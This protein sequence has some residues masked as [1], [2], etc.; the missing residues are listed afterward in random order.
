MNDSL[1]LTLKFIFQELSI[2]DFERSVQLF[3]I[4]VYQVKDIL[5]LYI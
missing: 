2:I 3:L 4:Y 5:L 1:F